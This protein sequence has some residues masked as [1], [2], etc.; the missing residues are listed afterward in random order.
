MKRK[1]A[2]N[3]PEIQEIAATVPSPEQLTDCI[4]RAG[5]ETKLEA[6]GFSTDE[7]AEAVNHSHYLRNR[8]NV[9]KL[10]HLLGIENTKIS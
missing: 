8:F 2:D 4:R 9:D 3:W 10:G 5:G 6:L 7:I 1:V